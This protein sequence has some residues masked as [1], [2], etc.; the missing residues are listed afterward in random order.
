MWGQARNEELTEVGVFA[1]AEQLPEVGVG[2][3][4]KG[5]N[6][7]LEKMVLVGV[8]IYSVDTRRRRESVGE[9]VVTCG[10]DGE[11]NII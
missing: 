9:N 5:C 11:N 4:G 6:F 1:N 2:E 3:G 7:E 8:E 10:G